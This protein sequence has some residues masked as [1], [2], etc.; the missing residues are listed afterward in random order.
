MAFI[1][2]Y[3]V[4][5]SQYGRDLKTESSSENLDITITL[6]SNLGY[7]R[8]QYEQSAEHSIEEGSYSYFDTPQGIFDRLQMIS[9]DDALISVD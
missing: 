8:Q 5:Y 1:A 4:P 9:P 2:Y 3:L 7:V 6:L